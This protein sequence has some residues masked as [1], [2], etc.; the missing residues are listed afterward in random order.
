MAE[1]LAKQAGTPSFTKSPRRCAGSPPRDQAPQGAEIY[2]NVDFFS[3]IV[4]SMIGIPADMFTRFSPLAASWLVRH[5]LE[6][7]FGGAHAKPTIYRP[8]AEYIGRYCGLE[9]CTWVPINER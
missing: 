2:A 5:Y 6:E 8:Q 7:R 3:A 1:K 4:N 9:G